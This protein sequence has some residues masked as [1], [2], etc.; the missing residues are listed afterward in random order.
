M[1][2][3]EKPFA[4]L[5]NNKV[6]REFGSDK[7]LFPGTDDYYSHPTFII[8][9]L[10]DYIHLVT[11]IS[12]VNKGPYSNTVIFRGISD[13]QYNLVPGLA[14]LKKSDEDTELDL[15]NDFLTRRPD[16]FNGLSDFDILAKMQHYGLP[17]R[18]LDFSLNPL[19]ALYFACES[20][21]TKNGRILCHSTYLQNDTSLVTNAICSAAVRK[22][23]DD[24]YT[25]DEYLCNEK[26]SLRKYLIDVYLCGETI[27]VRPKYWNQRIANQ[28][29]VFMV[30]PNNLR[31]RYKNVLIHSG[32]QEIS[33]VI[34]NYGFGVI[35]E[36][37]IKDILQ[38]EPINY[39]KE[40]TEH[41]L[42]DE[43]IRIMID[44]Y[45]NKPYEEGFG[46]KNIKYFE[47]RFKMDSSLKMLDSEII[48]NSFCS[49]IV[50]SKN[51]KKILREL[52]NVGIS[53]DYIYPEL[54][55]TAKEIKRKY[56]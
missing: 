47:N 44:S 29:G 20:K 4:T 26:L 41:Y 50:E 24:C 5:V 54:E 15:I 28:A 39:Y 3:N 8:K 11:S 7:I 13:F 18:L 43:C 42:S 17:T 53:T 48:Q 25:V 46:D 22:M 12:S 16:A 6:L 31:D 56:E 34:Q 27:V 51:K 14:R 19:V 35:D 52:S 45:K 40:D 21:T 2:I 1:D 55:Y 30:F 9:N 32:E 37:I 49:I 36:N 23:F 38:N 33:K 10:S